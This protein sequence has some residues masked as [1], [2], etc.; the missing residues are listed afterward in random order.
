[1]R[2]LVTGGAGFIGQHLIRSLA[3]DQAHEVVIL[4]NFVRGRIESFAENS[5]RVRVVRGDVRDRICVQKS[6]PRNGCRHTPRGAIECPW[7]DSKS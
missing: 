7:G 2:I 3:K 4:D 6:D 1:M 5:G